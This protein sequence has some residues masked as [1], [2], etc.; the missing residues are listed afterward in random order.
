MFFFYIF[1]FQEDFIFTLFRVSIIS[2]SNVGHWRTLQ[3]NPSIHFLF[4]SLIGAAGGAGPYPST[5]RVK[6]STDDYR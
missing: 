4:L 1:S 3:G 2:A 6:F 5:S